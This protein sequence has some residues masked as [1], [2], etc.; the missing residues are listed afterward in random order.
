MK[1]EHNIACEDNQKLQSEGMRIHGDDNY[2][3]P[4]VRSRNA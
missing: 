1:I 2:E 4:K 3:M